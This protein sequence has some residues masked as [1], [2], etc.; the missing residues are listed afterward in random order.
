VTQLQLGQQPIE[1]VVIEIQKSMPLEVFRELHRIAYFMECME[2][3]PDGRVLW[4]A[5]LVETYSELLADA[6]WECLQN[7]WIEVSMELPKALVEAAA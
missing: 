5:A 2:R 1:T 6:E 7:D 3:L 4:N